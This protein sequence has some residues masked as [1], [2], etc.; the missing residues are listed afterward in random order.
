MLQHFLASVAF[1]HEISSSPHFSTGT[2]NNAL[3]RVNH[4]HW[5]EGKAFPLALCFSLS[6]LIKWKYDTF[7]YV[8]IWNLRYFWGIVRWMAKPAWQ[9]KGYKKHGWARYIPENSHYRYYVILNLYN[10]GVQLIWT[11]FSNHN[12]HKAAHI[13]WKKPVYRGPMPD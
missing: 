11:P 3:W 9:N 8:I 7:V 6:E 13:C 4:F 12:F 10:Q 2:Y 5:F 1:R